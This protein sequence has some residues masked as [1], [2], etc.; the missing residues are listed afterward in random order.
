MR[1]ITDIARNKITLQEYCESRRNIDTH[2]FQ[3]IFVP[4][5]SILCLYNL[6]D[7]CL[8]YK[9]YTWAPSNNLLFRH[10]D[11]ARRERKEN[12]AEKENKNNQW[13]VALMNAL[14]LILFVIFLFFDISSDIILLIEEIKKLC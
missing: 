13:C 12:E 11:Q 2:S 1:N 9:D 4:L 8:V 14:K 5:M 7:G 10:M 3:V 6:F